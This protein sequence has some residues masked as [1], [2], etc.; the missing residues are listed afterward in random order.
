M[1]N[2]ALRWIVLSAALVISFSPRMA[3]SASVPD[4]V[5]PKFQG[6]ISRWLAHH[7]N[8]RIAI[9]ADCGCPDDIQT[10]RAGSMPGWPPN[11]GFHPYYV[12]GDFV[13]D[14]IEDVAIGVIALKDPTKFRVLILHGKDLHGMRRA[15]FMSE[16]L[17]IRQGLFFGA[18]RPKPWRLGVGPF[19]SEG[20]LFEPT[21][22]GYRLSDSDEDAD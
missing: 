20:V 16:R 2:V 9:D 22:K 6:L 15:A 18:P 7:S 1:L 12:A 21:A 5:P 19:E 4:Y 17:D 3:F 8:Y 10:L 14:G 11:P 13:G